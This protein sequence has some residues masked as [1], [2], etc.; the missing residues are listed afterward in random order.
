MDIE[1]DNLTVTNE[2]II[3]AINVN[4]IK[5]QDEL[6]DYFENVES[7]EQSNSSR[8]GVV[9]FEYFFFLRTYLC[10][11]FFFCFSIS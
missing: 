6:S 10:I 3:E 1:E 7:D 4:L 5:F 8:T 11:Y 9:C 2:Q